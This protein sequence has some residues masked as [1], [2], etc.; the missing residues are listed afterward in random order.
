MIKI[1]TYIN[2]FKYLK[3]EQFYFR[4]IRK[5]YKPKITETYKGNFISHSSNWIHVELY[6][7]KI[8]DNSEASFLN[9]TKILNLPHDWNDELPSKLWVY[10]LHYFE[11]LL[12]VNAFDRKF[13]LTK[14]LNQWVSDNSD[15]SGNAWE[16]YPSSLRIVNVLK[17][18]LG[19]LDIDQ[20][21]L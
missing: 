13:F 3:W 14:L 9:H 15:S 5:I 2:T 16:A 20:K 10:N 19:G 1:L 4:L 8:K 12:S 18:W 7:P 11:D 6:E 21:M 17:A